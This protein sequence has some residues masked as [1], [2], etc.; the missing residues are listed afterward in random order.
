M[1]FESSYFYF[2]WDH[3]AHPGYFENRMPFKPALGGV[4]SL[5]KYSV[6]NEESQLNRVFDFPDFMC[7]L[8]PK[9]IPF[10]F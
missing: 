10:Y 7:S 5:A 6:A 3:W 4:C 9:A 8:F 2:F 1:E